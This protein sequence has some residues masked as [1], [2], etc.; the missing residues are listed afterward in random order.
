MPA[1]ARQEFYKQMVMQ[2]I[3]QILLIVD[4]SPVL[5]ELVLYAQN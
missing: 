3:I 5:L 4:P 1:T 2:Q